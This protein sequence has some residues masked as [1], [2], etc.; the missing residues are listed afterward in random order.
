MEGDRKKEM[1]ASGHEV[2]VQQIGGASVKAWIDGFYVPLTQVREHL[3]EFPARISE[4]ARDLSDDGDEWEEVMLIV[5]YMVNHDLRFCTDCQ[6]FYDADDVVRTGM[7]GHKCASCD[8]DDKYCEEN[9]D[10]NEHEE[11]CLN[12]RQRTN[13]KMATKYQCDHCGRIRRT[14]PT[15]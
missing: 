6:H 13:A 15:G 8:A 2:T 3:D 12:P 11:T 1:E 7:A 5:A 14:T 9:P 4:H 10:G